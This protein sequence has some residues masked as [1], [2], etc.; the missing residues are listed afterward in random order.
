MRNQELEAINKAKQAPKP[1]EPVAA[2]AAAAAADAEGAEDAA[3][4]AKAEHGAV[5]KR[6][7]AAK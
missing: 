3:L 2:V 6:G 7:S 4:L 5:Q 1:A